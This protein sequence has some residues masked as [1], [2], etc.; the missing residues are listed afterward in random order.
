MLVMKMKVLEIYTNFIN[1]LL[2]IPRNNLEAKNKN[3]RY[4]YLIRKY[5]VSLL[6]KYQNIEKIIEEELAKE[7]K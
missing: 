1:R 2:E 3:N 4:D 7:G 5:D 6:E